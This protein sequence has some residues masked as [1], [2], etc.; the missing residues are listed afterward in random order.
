MHRRLVIVIGSLFFL[1]P[2]FSKQIKV[3]CGTDRERRKE[4]LH[5]H[6]QAE[7]AR[8]AARMQ[9]NGA[10]SS[11]RPAA[12]SDIGNVVVLEDSDGVVAQRNPFNLDLQTLT[13][14]PSAPVSAR[15]KF[16]LAGDRY[17]SAAASHGTVVP[18]GDDDFHEVPLPFSFAFFGKQYQS[19]FI[20]SDGDL[21]FSEGDNATTERSLGRMVAGPPRIAPLFRDLDPSKTPKGITFASD[22][23]RF[24]VSWNQVQEYADFGMGPQQTFQVRLYPDGRI[25]FAYAGISTTSTV[26]GITPGNFLG[27]SSVV[28]FIAGSSAEYSSTVAERFG[29]GNEIDIQTAAQKFYE[30]HDDAYD[31]IAFFNN[32]NIA[33]GPGSVSWEQTV[34]NSRSGYGDFPVDDAGQ[35]GSP[36][37]LQAVLNLGPL[38]QFP[39]DPTDILPVR[40]DSGYNTLKLISHEAGHL[41]LAYASVRNPEDSAARPMLGIQMAHWAFNFNAEAS[42]ME[43]NLVQDKGASAAPRYIVADTVE[44]Y[45]P[46]DQYLMGF[47]PASEVAPMFLVTGNPPAFSQRFP[48]AGVTFSGGRR[49]I[50]VDDVIE[51]EG[52]RTPDYTVAQRHFRMAFVLIVKQG[53]TPSA[54]ELTQVESYRSQFEPFYEQAA[55]GRAHIDLSLRHALT[56]SLAPAAGV[57]VGS[58][59]PATISIQQ[60]AAAPLVISLQSDGNIAVPSSV[61]IPAG[62]TSVNF[63]IA[64]RQQS[65]GD[66]TA[67]PSDN[68]YDTAYARIQ[69]LQPAALTLS[70]VSGNKQVI[71]ANGALA[72]PVVVRASDINLLFYPGVRVQ[73]IANTGG[74]VTPQVGTTDATGSVSFQWT[75]GT[76]AG[77]QLQVF[78]EGTS[79][80]AGVGITALPPTTINAA[81]IVNAAS[82]VTGISPG[83]LATIYGTTLAGGAVASATVPWPS[84]LGNV[85]VLV[86]NEPSQLLYVSDGQINFMA[87][88]DLVPGTAALT[89]LT[90]AGTLASIQVPVTAVAPG[91]FFDTASNFGAILNSGTSQTTQQQPAARGQFIEIYCTGLGAIKHDGTGLALTVAQPQVLIGNVPAV[92]QFSGLAPLFGGGLYQVNV[93]IPQN[94][95]AGTQPL[96]LTINGVASNSVKVGIQ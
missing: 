40:A 88:G 34:R 53:T 60:P 46:L 69:T 72:Q 54:A 68:T 61:T 12:A 96:I 16:Q 4:E 22:P 79:P 64:G 66:L 2:A 63:T 57:L 77:G 95:P 41:F 71:G 81:G 39:V 14:T 48:Q 83:G 91:I 75:P 28:S 6:R 20:N 11:P 19:V 17:D 10:P 50:Q 56:L 89:V 26:V 15:Y 38:S 70:T 18:L 13:F 93:Q 24:I 80:S 44:Q 51:A 86:N 43:G 37:R 49:D 3:I 74:T 31:Y 25:Q 76:A 84:D 21:T 1:T 94:A 65:V 27:S 58:S 23:T 32:M 5:L 42:F 85:Q 47:R 33:T 52:R 29:G 90:G 82:F 30:T 8:R 78:L 87:P 59:S 9:A 7:L 92:V 73:A 62:A 36:S 35:Y 67:T 55:G 45:S